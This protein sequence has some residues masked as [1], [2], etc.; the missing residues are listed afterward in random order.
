MR[1]ER[2]GCVRGRGRRMYVG[3]ITFGDEGLRSSLPGR[4]SATTL[5]TCSVVEGCS[6]EGSM[7]GSDTAAPRALKEALYRH[8]A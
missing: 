6:V 7:E 4:P 1:G 3:G 5:S 8:G 2:K